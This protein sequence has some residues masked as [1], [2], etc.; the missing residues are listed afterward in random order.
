MCVGRE[1]ACRVEMG[2]GREDW[3]EEG[4]GERRWRYASGEKEDMV[5]V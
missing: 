2:E 5:V 3:E 1:E 4:E